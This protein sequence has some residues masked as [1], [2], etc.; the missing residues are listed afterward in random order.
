MRSFVLIMVCI[1]TIQSVIAQKPDYQVWNDFLENHVDAEGWVDYKSISNNKDELKVVLNMLVKNQ[2]LDDWSQDERK[3]Y[4]INAYNA[5]TIKLI[6]DHYPLESIRDINGPWQK[7]FIPWDGDL[8]D[9]D[10]IEHDILRKT[11]DPRIHFAINCASVSCP[12]LLNRAYIPELLDEQLDQVTA[13]FINNTEK[14]ELGNDRI[15]LSKIFRWYRQ[16]FTE[17]EELIDF[18]NRYAAQKV[19]PGTA[20]TFMDYNW[21]LNER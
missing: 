19:E 14:N 21:A 13:G 18:L 12:K 8:I 9:L 11:G 10:H 17:G 3:A 4:W 20:V 1:T 5:Y 16:D 6:I 15:R 2:P 7:D